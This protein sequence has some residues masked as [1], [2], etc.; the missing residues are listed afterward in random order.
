MFADYVFEVCC[1]NSALNCGDYVVS[2][3]DEPINMADCWNDTGRGKLKYSEK[4][5]FHCHVVH[6]KSH[7][8]WPGIKLGLERL[9]TN[10][11][12]HDTGSV[13][14]VALNCEGWTVNKLYS[15]LC[16]LISKL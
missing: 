6:H 12:S 1:L 5:L 3:I 4:N 13:Y 15:I 7:M 2:V 14:C 16:N 8:D 11:C 9:V 10:S